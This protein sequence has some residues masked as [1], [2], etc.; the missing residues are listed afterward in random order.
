MISFK[1]FLED[2]RA[3]ELEEGNPL[4]RVQSH[5][6]KD[7]HMA[8]ISAARSDKSPKENKARNRELRRDIVKSGHGYRKA[9]GKWEGGSE[10]SVVVHSRGK[11]HNN[12][13]LYTMKRLSKKYGQDGVFLHR[14]KGKV[15]GT[16]KTSDWPGYG[17]R[18]DVGKLRYNKSNPDSETEFKP[19]K[20]EGKRPKFTT[21]KP[22]K[23]D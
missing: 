14:K 3:R 18:A 1:Q 10:D 20:P 12:A 16:N 6:D 2:E 19:T 17:K 11:Q 22:K 21:M 15:I 13:L 5:A 4:A 8:A 9:K 23:D 7:V